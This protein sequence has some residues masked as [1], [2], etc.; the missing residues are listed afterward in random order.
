MSRFIAGGIHLF[1]SLLVGLALLTMSWFVWYP[2]PTL[3]AIGGQDIFLLIVAIDVVLGPLL[4]LI[5]F[6]SGKPSLKFDLIV[7][8]ALQVAAML[9][10]ISSLF[11]ARPAYIAALGDSF[12]V[13]QATEVT[14]ANLAKANATMPWFGPKWVGTKAPEDRYDID[15]VADVTM[16]GG[17][18]G[19]F[20]QLHVPIETVQLDN[21]LNAK[22]ISELRKS[23]P[24]ENNQ[25][26]KWLSSHGYN[27][28]SVKFQPI[29]INAITYVVMLDAKSGHAIGMLA[30][31]I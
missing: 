13:V 22:A 2:A 28:D 4:T 29:K 15:A 24:T 3:L 1:L 17:G 12:Q 21:L 16:S 9:Y 23:K 27:D 5:V 14:D 18:R 11:E 19:H 10:G 25:I 20:P 7:I 31:A 6:K 8:A 26:D 30:I